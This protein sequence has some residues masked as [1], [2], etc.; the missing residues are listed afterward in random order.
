MRR[1][2]GGHLRERAIEATLFLAASSA[3]LATGAIVF[4]LVWESAPFFRQVGFREFLTA[5]EWSPLFSNP[6]YGILPLLSGTLVTTAVALLL[7]VPMGI[8]SAV[9]LSEYAPARAR[10]VLKPLLELLAAVPTVV[11]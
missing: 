4:I 9:F 2:A 3:V 8:I 6:R 5:T 10:E 7:A 11:Y 1:R